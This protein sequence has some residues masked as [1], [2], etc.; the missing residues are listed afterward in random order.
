MTK[1]DSWWLRTFYIAFFLLAS[2]AGW[3]FAQTVGVQANWVERY[4]EW[5]GTAAVV[6]AAL[7]GGVGTWYLASDK[8]RNDYLLAVVGELRKVSWPNVVDTRRMT[9]IVCVVVGI[10]AIILAIFDF[11]W[12]RVLSLLLS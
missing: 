10:F 7:A 2:F 9:V 8:G 6:F 1:D 4:D 12:G 11:I 3:K 5:F